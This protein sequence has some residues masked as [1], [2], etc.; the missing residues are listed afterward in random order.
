MLVEAGR[1]AEAKAAFDRYLA[2]R[3][4]APAGLIARARLLAKTGDMQA[5]AQDFSRAIALAKQPEPEL[6]IERA[7]A[8][9]RA[10]DF[11]AALRSLDEGVT[12]LG[13]LITLT[14]PAIDLEVEAGRLDAALARL[15][16]I[17]V[18]A[19]RKERWLLL[20]GSLLEKSGQLEAARAAYSAAQAA[21]AKVPPDRRGSAAMDELSK[22]IESAQTRVATRQGSTR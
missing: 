22:N 2:A 11:D 5:A 14:Q 15:A 9:R 12:R 17:I 1:P 10:G 13:P 3:P 20:R 19:P 7:Q 6:F 16:K 8:L 18:V 4:D 21:F